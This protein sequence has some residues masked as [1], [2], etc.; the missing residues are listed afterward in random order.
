[1]GRRRA[2]PKAETLRESRTLNP[3]PES[4]AD[5]RFTDSEFFDARDLVQVKYEMVRRVEV[6][7]VSVT[8]AAAAFGFSRQSYYQAA[9]AV[10]ESGPAAWFPPNRGPR[11]RANSPTRSSTISRNSWPPTPRCDR[12]R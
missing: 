2:D 12:R 11:V 7:G 4:V 5:E 10:A 6:D 1:M 3:H 9:A 8:T